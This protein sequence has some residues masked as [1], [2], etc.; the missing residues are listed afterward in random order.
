MEY[1][2]DK[3]HI[4]KKT[5]ALLFVLFFSTLLSCFFMNKTFFT[6]EGWYSYYAKLINTGGVVYKDFE[7]LFTP[8]YMY[9]IALVTKIFGTNI[10]V[11]RIM[12]VLVFDIIAVLIFLICKNLFKDYIAALVSIVGVFYFQS[13]NYQVFYDYVRVMDIFSFLSVFLMLQFLFTTDKLG[14]KVVYIVLW[15]LTSA[16]YFLI[17]QNMGA[18]S[19]VYY[20]GVI[21]FCGFFMRQKVKTVLKYVLCFLVSFLVPILVFCAFMYK[22]DMLQIMFQ[23]VFMNAIGAKGGL[24]VILF[25]WIGNVL[26]ELIKVLPYAICYIALCICF[27]MI[28]G[29]YLDKKIKVKSVELLFVGIILFIGIILII[30]NENIGIFISSQDRLKPI[31]IFTL[32]IFIIIYEMI[33][34]ISDFKNKN[35]VDLK[36]ISYVIVGGAFF[37]ITYGAGMSGGLSI[38]ESGIGIAFVIGYLINKIEFIGGIVARGFAYYF[39]IMSCLTSMAIKVI[40]PNQWWGINEES[41]YEMKYETDIP[42]LKGIKVSESEKKMYEG[43]CE[44]VNENTT[45]ED[46]IYCFPHIPIIYEMTNRM[47]PGVYGKVQWF[48]V[49]DNETLK[50]DTEII[51]EMK[52]RVIIIY[53]LKDSTYE[54]HEDLFNYGELSGTRYMRDFLY[55]FVNTENY[56]YEGT[57]IS[58]DNNISVYV[59]D[60]KKTDRLANLYEG[61]GTKNDPYIIRD[62]TDLVNLSMLVNQN[63]NLD[64]IY[65]EQQNDISLK[66]VWWIPIGFNENKSEFIYNFNGK[67]VYDI[68]NCDINYSNIYK[69][70]NKSYS[71]Q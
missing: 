13:D 53:N 32:D 40:A 2:S 54:G 63:E 66:N 34:L 7:Y 55:E 5:Y 46:S 25:R 59:V 45:E 47:D 36:N 51:S 71:S 16:C 37:A 60:D 28:S 8:L 56:R 17:K 31:I 49:S 19:T 33:K 3:R 41:I 62:D 69:S 29:K 35:E 26:P 48:D 10:I 11:L 57:F 52:P 43:I 6:A 58:A 12:G 67:Y 4:L 64:G 61:T 65:F 1:L 70:I 44:I 42:I 20:I 24:A 14:K 27:E 15:G 18:L 68:N 21:I 38:G 22:Q 9:I 39:C 23:S 50:K 30:V